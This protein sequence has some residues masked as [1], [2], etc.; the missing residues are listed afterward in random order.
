[1]RGNHYSGI[2]FDLGSDLNNIFD[3]TVMDAQVWA[4]ES[5]AVMA[6]DTLNNLTNLSSRNIGSGLD[7][8]LLTIG[9]PVLD[10]PH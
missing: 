5:V 7:P 9:Q 6:N 10:P 4:L 2:F 8:A 3:N 1:M